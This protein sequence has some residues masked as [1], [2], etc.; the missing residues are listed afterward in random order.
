MFLTPKPA[1]YAGQRSVACGKGAELFGWGT[2]YGGAGKS[3]Q[4]APAAPA[5][6]APVAPEAPTSGAY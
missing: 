1:I 4:A 5:Q 2:A 3:A 6:A